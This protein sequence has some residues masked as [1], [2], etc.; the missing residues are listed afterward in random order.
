MLQMSFY[1]N[2]MTCGWVSSMTSKEELVV[3]QTNY[4]IRGFGLLVPPL[5][6][7]EKREDK[8]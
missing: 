7:W 5:T 4:V 1:A 6:S 3:R 8:S 2:K